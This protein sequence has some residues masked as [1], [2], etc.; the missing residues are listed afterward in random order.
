MNLKRWIPIWI[1]AGITGYVFAKFTVELG[2][3]EH[4]SPTF[5]S[6]AFA[7]VLLVTIWIIIQIIR[8]CKDQD[9]VNEEIMPNKAVKIGGNNKVISVIVASVLVVYA[10]TKRKN[11]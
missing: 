10:L 4:L 7:F 1:I 8:D 9:V 3:M 6:Y 5:T 2:G 11:K